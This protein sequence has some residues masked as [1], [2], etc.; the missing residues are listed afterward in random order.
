MNT[1]NTHTHTHTRARTHTDTTKSTV[2]KPLARY[3]QPRPGTD[4]V[5]GGFVSVL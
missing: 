3:R 1:H 4:L 5:G 2:I